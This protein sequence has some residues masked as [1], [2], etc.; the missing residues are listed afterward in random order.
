MHQHPVA[1]FDR[2]SAPA[3]V[4]LL[5]APTSADDDLLWRLYCERRRP[6]TRRWDLP[7]AALEALLR[8]QQRFEQAGWAGDFAGAEHFI[9]EV[10]GEPVGRT[11]Y[12][13]DAARVLVVDMTFLPSMQGR[14][15]GSRLFAELIAASRPLPVEI[16]MFHDARSRDFGVKLGFREVARDDVY[17]R[18]RSA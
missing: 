14:G 5:R 7:P 2:S 13:R 17:V 6:E 1:S 4:I 3:P 9:I 10:D 18:M 11:I 12:H 15:I 8:M 16:S